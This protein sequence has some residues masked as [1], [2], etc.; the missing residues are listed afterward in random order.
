MIFQARVNTGTMV[1]YSCIACKITYVNM[2]EKY[3]D[4]Q[5]IY[6]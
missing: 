5:D 6:V 1:A 2:Q 3:V 4:M